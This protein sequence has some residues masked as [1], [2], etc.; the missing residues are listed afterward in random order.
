MAIIIGIIVV[1]NSVKKENRKQRDALDEGETPSKSELRKQAKKE[2]KLS[3]K[4]AKKDA[5]VQAKLAV[6]EEKAL[7]KQEKAVAKQEK[8]EQTAERTKAK[9]TATK[10]MILANEPAD[11]LVAI[12]GFDPYAPIDTSECEIAEEYHDVEQ[13]TADMRAL[14]EKLKLSAQYEKKIA[15]L[16][17]RL[18]KIRYEN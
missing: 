11:M 17:T 4:Q 2:R 5:K 14:R 12:L 1:V 9:A 8:I 16:K 10:A 3:K 13:E 15:T 6:K 18:T 7:V